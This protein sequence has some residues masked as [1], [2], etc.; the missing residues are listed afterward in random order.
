MRTP[1]KDRAIVSAAAV[2]LGT[3]LGILAFGV[4]FVLQDAVWGYQGPIQARVSGVV[5][6]A[7]VV[8]AV[9]LAGVPSLVAAA[10]AVL[11]GFTEVRGGKVSR[12]LMSMAVGTLSGILVSILVWRSPF[13]KKDFQGIQPLFFI[14]FVCA[15]LMA[16]VLMNLGFVRAAQAEKSP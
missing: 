10:L 1:F 13:M 7:L 15:A 4:V 3:F 9:S 14:G 2:L 11:P 12:L 16:S 5:D 8:R 6:A